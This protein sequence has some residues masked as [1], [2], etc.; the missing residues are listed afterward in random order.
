M[1]PKQWRAG[2]GEDFGSYA[3]WA[4]GTYAEPND[5]GTAAYS[6]EEPYLTLDFRGSPPR[7]GQWNDASNLAATRDHQIKGYVA[8]APAPVPEP[9]TMLLLGFGLVGWAGFG[10]KNLFK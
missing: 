2:T 10:R 5:W 7:T 8:E 3:N 1:Q 4:N 9:A 6:G